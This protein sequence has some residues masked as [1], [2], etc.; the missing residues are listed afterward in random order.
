MVT[1]LAESE[2]CETNLHFNKYDEISYLF[3][4][5]SQ[6]RIWVGLYP[7]IIFNLLFKGYY[8]LQKINKERNYKKPHCG[9][10]LYE[11]FKRCDYNTFRKKLINFI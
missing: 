9:K 4:Y 3:Y 2:Y 11:K 6:I 7:F 8:Y 10:L 5:K 1:I